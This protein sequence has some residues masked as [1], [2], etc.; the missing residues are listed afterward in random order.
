[1]LRRVTDFEKRN[2]KPC[3]DNISNGELEQLKQLR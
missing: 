3:G 2:L 1:M